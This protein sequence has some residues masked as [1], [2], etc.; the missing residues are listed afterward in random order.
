VIPDLDT[1]NLSM[2]GSTSIEL[3]EYQ[4]PRLKAQPKDVLGL[5]VV[6][7]GGNDIIHDYG[8][9]PP[10]EHAMFG[11]TFEQA[12]PWIAAFEERLDA[13][14]AG[15]ETRFPGGCHIFIA[16]I[17]DP[18]DGVGDIEGAGMGLPAWGDGLKILHA[19]NDVIAR[20]AARRASAHLVNVHDVLLGHGI[21][22]TDSGNENYDSQDPTYWYYW[23]LEDPNDRGY[24]AIR[25]AFLLEMARCV[26]RATGPDR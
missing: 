4:L 23:N 7:T 6:T 1:L 13:L 16:S 15:I 5:V 3:L 20:C 26:P 25:R 22:C 24:D 17:Y 2:S 18:T 11:A 8:R 9:A 12:E 14:L 10:R 19:Y 21:H